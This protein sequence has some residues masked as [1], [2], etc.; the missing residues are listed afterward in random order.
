MTVLSEMASLSPW[1]GVAVTVLSATWI[2]WLF[3]LRREA[4]P[5]VELDVN[6]TFV[7]RQKGSLLIE[8]EAKLTN[9]GKVREWYRQFRVVVRY[10]LP[11]DEIIDGP[12]K[13]NYQLL[14]SRT[15]DDR[16]GGAARY[17]ANSAYI[18]PQLCYQHRYVTFVP[19]EAVFVW[20]QVRM[21]FR[22]RDLWRPWK[23]FE[24]I[25]NSQRLFRVPAEVPETVTSPD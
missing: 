2:V 14:C 15:I 11:D 21:A 19:E 18:D 9:K 22:R 4:E 25:K 20:I 6:I 17:F 3:I 8:A 13:L 12:P 23:K 7:G 1:W 5:I 16:I 24:E 10:I